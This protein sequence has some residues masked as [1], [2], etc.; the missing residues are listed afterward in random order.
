MKVSIIIPYY[1]GPEEYIREALDSA[2][3]QTFDSYEILV[4]DDGS[5]PEHH[6][7]LEALCT[8]DERIR[9]FTIAHAGVSAARNVG[10]IRARGEYLSF[11]DADDVLAED[12]LDRAWA[13]VQETESE[14]VIGG[15]FL[16]EEPGTCRFPDREQTPPCRLWYGDEI[17]QLLP[18]F[19]G[20]SEQIFF[21][22]GYI[23]KGPISR[24][25][26][27]DLAR[28]AMFDE[29]LKIGEDIIWMLQLL[30]EC[31]RL[32]LV[33]EVWY[34]Y[35][36]NPESATHRYRPAYVEE[37]KAHIKYLPSI[38]DLRDD[39]EYRAYA[40]RIYEILQLSWS[41]MLREERRRNPRAYRSD[42]R[43][44]YTELPWTE[45]CSARFFRMAKG[46][47]KIGVLLFRAHAFFE[48]KALK[49]KLLRREY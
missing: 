49:E 35:R 31:E 37:S 36:I 25:I 20:Q 17:R 33:R 16:F 26:R 3:N 48:A 32:C 22:G 14:I 6:A 5:S 21:S 28:K 34:A 46:K 13:V 12:F 43:R 40:E 47:K 24:L 9:L 8:G 7:A 18:A 39:R 30:K 45:I 29:S 44:L 38:L 23:N 41:N 1:N 42:T 27:S 2:R 4:V 10:M 11:L 19:V 15:T